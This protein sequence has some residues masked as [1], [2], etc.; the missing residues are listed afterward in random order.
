MSKHFSSS[1]RHEYKKAIIFGCSS[2]SLVKK[3]IEQPRRL[4]RWISRQVCGA[5]ELD[6]L[7]ADGALFDR[8]IPIDHPLSLDRVLQVAL[9]ARDHQ[10]GQAGPSSDPRRIG[11]RPLIVGAIGEKVDAIRIDAGRFNFLP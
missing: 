11:N 10:F 1:Q 4:S 9:H 3:S 2:S 8:V 5:V 7:I 6:L